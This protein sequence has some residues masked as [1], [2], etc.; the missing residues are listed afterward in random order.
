MLGSLQAE[1]LRP[2]PLRHQPQSVRC[3][4]IEIEHYSETIPPPLG[5]NDPTLALV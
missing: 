5:R 1:V 3:P 2:V 4:Q